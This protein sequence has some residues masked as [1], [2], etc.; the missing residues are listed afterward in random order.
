L[1]SGD[2]I[3]LRC[4]QLP[5]ACVIFKYMS[6][7]KKLILG[8]L[9]ITAIIV[10]A[11]VIQVGHLR[12]NISKIIFDPGMSN[13]VNLDG[14]QKMKV[15]LTQ[16]EVIRLL[17]DSTSK[18]Q[19]SLKG[20]HIMSTQNFW[21]YNYQSGAFQGPNPKAYVVFYDSKGFVVSF[22]EPLIKN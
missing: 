5:D 9:F 17:G 7:K 3:P 1:H 20:E 8:A 6:K 13:A 19:I 10:V 12:Q 18:K 2:C 11:F 16:D 15:G 4:M 22:R 14:W 21:E